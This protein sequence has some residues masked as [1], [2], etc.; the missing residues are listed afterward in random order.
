MFEIHVKNFVIS[1]LTFEYEPPG[2]KEG[3]EERHGWDVV[4]LL[5]VVV[6]AC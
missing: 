3:L 5:V 6:E 4:V 2:G 1:V